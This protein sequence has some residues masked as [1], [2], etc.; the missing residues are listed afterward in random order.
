MQHVSSAPPVSPECVL[1]TACWRIPGI[2]KSCSNSLNWAQKLS[3]FLKKVDSF[4]AEPAHVSMNI[5]QKASRMKELYFFLSYCPL[6]K[7]QHF[8]QSDTTGLRPFRPDTVDSCL[9]RLLLLN[10]TCGIDR[11]D[12]ACRN[13]PFIMCVQYIGSDCAHCIAKCNRYSICKLLLSTAGR[14]HS[15]DLFWCFPNSATYS[16][17]TGGVHAGLSGT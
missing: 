4:Q 10:A 12:L 16:M 15:M 3:Y 7:E 5:V 1:S 17:C 8:C 11:T 6:W 2:L 14:Y 13:P 9:C